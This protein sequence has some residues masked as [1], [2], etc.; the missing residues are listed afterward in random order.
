M[1]LT[2]DQRDYLARELG[3]AG[4]TPDEASVVLQGIAN[5]K[6]GERLVVVPGSCDGSPGK[7]TVRFAAQGEP[8][9]P[10]FTPA[11]HTTY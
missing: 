6:A 11:G 3:K 8:M 1:Q 10:M 4:A 2:T 5:A 7:W 9:L